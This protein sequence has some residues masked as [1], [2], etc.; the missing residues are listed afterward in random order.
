MKKMFGIDISNWQSKYNYA[1]ATKEGV[2][3]VILRAGYGTIKDKSFETHYKQAK[4]QGWKIG[5]YWYTYATSV[6]KARKEAAA[7]LNA[8]KGKQ[9]EMPIYLDIEDA[10]IRKKEKVI[11]NDIV[12]AFGDMIEGANY[13]F[14]VYSN[15]YWYNTL[16]NGKELNKKYDWWIAKWSKVEPTSKINYGMW[17]F[18]GET[19][20]IKSNKVAG[21]VTDQNYCYKNYPGM[22]LKLRKNGFG[23][24]KLDKDV[25]ATQLKSTIAVAKEV[26][27]GKWGNG[28]TRKK[29]LTAAHYDY[30]YSKIQKKVNELLK[31]K[32]TVNHKV[33]KGE[34]LVT[35][36]KKYGIS[37]L[38]LYYKNKEKII[39]DAKRKGIKREFYNYI[40]EGQILQIR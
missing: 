38:S 30:D 23:L 33:K 31:E 3:F 7:Y 37:W 29:A 2:K 10:K 40:F 6:T 27:Q 20:Y 24:G 8:I 34:S 14:G 12:E 4:L 36:S 18:G 22:I 1:G 13:Y 39:S 17:Q 28:S 15:L 16:L 11:R 21:T 35:I 19:N 32:V 25:T 9:F 26:L 5:T